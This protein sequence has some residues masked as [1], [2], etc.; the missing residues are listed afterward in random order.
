MEKALFIQQQNFAYSIFE[1]CLKTAKSIKFVREFEN[2]RNAQLLYSKLHVAYEGGV[3]A[4]LRQEKIRQDIQEFRLDSK[5]SRTLESF[6]TSF[7]H[8]L[9]DLESVTLEPVSSEDKLKWLTAAIREHEQLYQAATMSKIVQQTSGKTSSMTYDDFYS[10]IL[11]HAQVLDQNSK[12]KASRRRKANAA[13]TIRK[14]DDKSKKDSKLKSGD[15]TAENGWVD[16]EKWKKMSPESRQ[17]HIEKWRKIRAERNKDQP[18]DGT[19]SVNTTKT[20]GK[21]NSKDD[22]EE[23]PPKV[24]PAP[25]EQLRTMLSANAAQHNKQ[26]TFAP[27]TPINFNGQ[28]FTALMANRTY[29]V[30]EHSVRYNHNG[31]MVDSGCNGGLAGDDVIVLEETMD[32]VDITGIADSKL[33]SVKIGTVAGV[34][35]TTDG[36]VIAIFHQYATYGKGKTIHSVTQFR[37]FGLEVNDIPKS[38][39]GGKQCITTPDGYTIPL[40]IRAGL[41][42]LD[43]RKPVD[44]EM[45]QLPHLILTSDTPWNP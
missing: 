6:L 41:C 36:P 10:M 31:S 26:V 3:S 13:K 2:N 7:E 39:P 29:H 37:S 20:K 16:S 18:P 35:N 5:W 1:R 34:I 19:R 25:G 22:K 4:E 43:M 32:T 28:M 23:V 14:G 17:K 27:G 42:Y 44:D 45:E 38:C 21:G 24:E 40:A 12:D 8:K 11:A 15:K 9:L 33:E 30:A